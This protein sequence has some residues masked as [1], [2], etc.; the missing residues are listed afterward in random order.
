LRPERL[1]LRVLTRYYNQGYT[2]VE[3]GDGDEL[4]QHR[5]FGAIR[6]AHQRV[7]D[8]LHA[9]DEDGRLHLIVGNQD[10]QGGRHEPVV[11]DGIAAPHGLVLEHA[12]TGQ[13]IFAVH[14]HLSA[15]S[16]PIRA[17]GSRPRKPWWGAA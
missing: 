12:D 6:A 8:L 7:F 13:D 11:K 15:V 17:T 14:G 2:Y 3:V 4:W 10:I 1:F 16:D 9:F 5:R